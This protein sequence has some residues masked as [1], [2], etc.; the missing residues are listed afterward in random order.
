[1]SSHV[2]CRCGNLAKW[3]ADPG[4]P[5]HYDAGSDTYS[6][7][8]SEQVAVPDAYC[9]FCGGHA[10]KTGVPKCRCGFLDRCTEQGLPI[11][12]DNMFYLNCTLQGEDIKFAIWYCPSCS[13]LA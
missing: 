4:V 12:L 2:Q 9:H 8:L 3:A 1:M 11:E 10:V 7:K 5:Y 13:G 6:L